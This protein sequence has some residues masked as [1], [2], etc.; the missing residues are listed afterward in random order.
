MTTQEKGKLIAAI[1]RTLKT[2]ATI[3]RKPFDDGDLFFALA[4]KSD[5]ELATIARLVHVE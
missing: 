5:S 1:L 2:T 3:Q 4:F